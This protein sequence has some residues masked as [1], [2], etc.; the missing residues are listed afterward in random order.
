MTGQRWYCFEVRRA[1]QSVYLGKCLTTETEIRAA[2]PCCVIVGNLVRILALK[3]A[4]YTF[5]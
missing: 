1:G 3:G 4:R 5:R 2:F